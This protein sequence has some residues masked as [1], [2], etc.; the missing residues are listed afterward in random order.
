MTHKQIA[1]LE[2]I[3]LA[4]AYRLYP[5]EKCMCSQADVMTLRLQGYSVR[6]VAILLSISKSTVWRWCN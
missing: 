2:Q 4:T 5:I 3:S 1:K 6:Q